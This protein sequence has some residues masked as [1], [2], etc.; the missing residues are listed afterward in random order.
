MDLES[1]QMIYL[2]NNAT[3]PLDS[4][5]RERL[6]EVLDSAP[7]NAS[8]MQH[9]AGRAAHEVVEDSRR[10][11]AAAL[12]VAP[13][14]VV[15]TAG[16]SEA[17]AMAVFGVVAAAPQGART[18]LLSPTE[19]KAVIAAAE[20]CIRTLGA[21]INYLDVD[22]SGR[23]VPDS[24]PPL[25]DDTVCLL[26]AMHSN[27]E[28]GVINPI[29]EIA[30]TCRESRA[31][32]LVDCTQS[33]GKIDVSAVV[34]IADL[35]PVSAHKAYGPKGVGALVVDRDVKKSL[36][37]MGP[38]GG[39]EFGLRGGTHNTAGIA[40]A[41]LAMEIA[42]QE[43]S[44]DSDKARRQVDQLW[45]GIRSNI[46]NVEIVTGKAERL[47]NT[48]NMRFVGTDAE[49]VMANAQELAVATGSACNS[50]N[51]EPSHVL[52]AMGWE[53]VA[54]EEC[55]R[56]STGRFTIDE[57]ISRTLVLLGDAVARVRRLTA[58]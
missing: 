25:L 31:R 57:D 45:T 18:I 32:L 9:F 53:R 52:S 48:I 6:I 47:P 17:I 20:A 41:A 56:V 35:C 24:I 2:D 19:H 8:S 42:I 54:A 40:A 58:A 30:D 3:T 39:Q 55:I 33:L 44:A 43:R 46:P 13:S 21:R 36:V 50:A 29:L 23:V 28:T 15:W 26:A 7:A 37:S 5:V 49:A 12:D 38:G 34:G 11:A 16:A 1:G 14:Q 4:R 10:Q 22:A 27:N 51:P